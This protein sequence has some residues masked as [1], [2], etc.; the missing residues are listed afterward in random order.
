MNSL[1]D[2]L[3]LPV[4]R[5]GGLKSLTPPVLSDHVSS[6][7]P[8][9]S[10]MT[11]ALSQISTNYD[12]TLRFIVDDVR[13]FLEP[14]DWDPTED[15]L[16]TIKRP[17]KRRTESFG[18]SL[19]IDCKSESTSDGEPCMSCR[20]FAGAT[21]YS[22]PITWSIC[23]ESLNGDTQYF[24]YSL[25]HTFVPSVGIGWREALS[26]VNH[27]DQFATLREE[28][29]L[30]ITATVRARESP[31]L[32]PN[33]TLAV[34]YVALTQSEPSDLRF[35]VYQAR[36]DSGRLSRSRELFANAEIIDE[37]CPRLGKCES[38]V[39]AYLGA[40]PQ[41][42]F[43]E[44]T[45]VKHPRRARYGLPELL[46]SDNRLQSYR[47]STKFDDGSD[48]E[49]DDEVDSTASAEIPDLDDDHDSIDTPDPEPQEMEVGQGAPLTIS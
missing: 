34:S 5:P 26:K 47:H 44:P 27:W 3:I 20:L 33:R 49:E 41:K 25:T 1:G 13:E 14:D 6:T 29:A 17:P 16:I 30:C 36:R 46:R 19:F 28:N 18:P 23:G 31:C 7:C 48:Y 45:G 8:L 39:H 40:V 35:I 32:S 22:G 24:K 11:T 38:D 21:P 37:A 15:S 10:N 42:E 12:I 2:R 4:S 9:A 43:N